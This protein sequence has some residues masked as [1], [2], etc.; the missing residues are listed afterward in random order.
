MLLGV[1]VLTS[2]TSSLPEIA[3][4][5]AVLVDPLDVSDLVRGIRRIAKDVDL[6][7]ELSRRGLLQAMKFGQNEYRSRL[8]AAYRRVGVQ[9]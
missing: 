2:N 4:E 3:G 5:A 7:A 6:R 9:T 8:A 1:P